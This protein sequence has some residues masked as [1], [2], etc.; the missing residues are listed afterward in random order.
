PVEVAAGIV[1]DQLQDVGDAEHSEPLLEARRD[2]G[3]A[4]DRNVPQLTKRLAHCRASVSALLS[5]IVPCCLSEV[6]SRDVGGM[7]GVREAAPGGH[8]GEPLPP[9]DEAALVPQHPA[10]PGCRGRYPQ[11]GSDLHLVSQGGEDPEGLTAPGP[12]PSPTPAAIAAVTKCF[13]PSTA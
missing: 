5:S 6:R 9:P 13:A 7:R 11:A 10:D 12:A 1:L 2:A 3:E 4:R 8:A